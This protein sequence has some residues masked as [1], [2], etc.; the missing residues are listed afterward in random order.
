VYFYYKLW[1]FS[2]LQSLSI[3]FIGST[4]SSS[5]TVDI[6]TNGCTSIVLLHAAT[7]LSR[8]LFVRVQPL[9]GYQKQVSRHICILMMA[10][11]VIAAGFAVCI[12]Y[13]IALFTCEGHISSGPVWAPELYCNNSGQVICTLV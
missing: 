12:N 9:I 5:S 3:A 10:L 11:D 2:W 1:C 7:G 8:V 6:D 4:L 13:L